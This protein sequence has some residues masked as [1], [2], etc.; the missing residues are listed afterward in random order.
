MHALDITHTVHGSFQQCR[1]VACK[2]VHGRGAMLK[3]G[4]H[5]CT[6]AH[7]HKQT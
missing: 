1:F 7:M 3:S 6:H 2:E 5:K 4:M